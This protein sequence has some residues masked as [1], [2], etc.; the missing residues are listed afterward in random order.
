MPKILVEIEVDAIIAPT[1]SSIK[2][3]SILD[4]I[5]N[6]WWDDY[7]TSFRVLEYT[8]RDDVKTCDACPIREL[9]W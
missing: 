1:A 7:V 3:D 6:K 4:S 5:T 2:I 8:E 9:K